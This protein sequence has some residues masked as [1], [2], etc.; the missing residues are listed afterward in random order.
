M[1]SSPNGEVCCV[2]GSAGIE[3]VIFEGGMIVAYSFHKTP[4]LFHDNIDIKG[5]QLFSLT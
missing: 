3:I 2:A 4:F 5:F 1:Q